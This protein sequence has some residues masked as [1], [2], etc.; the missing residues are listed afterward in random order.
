MAMSVVD[1]MN[2]Y[3]AEHIANLGANT[4]VLHQFRWAQ[5]FAQYLEARRRNQ[6]IRMEATIIFARTCGG[7]PDLRHEAAQPARGPAT[8]SA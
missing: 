2:L 1:G 5:D 3:I 7:T 4:F 6:P 8:K